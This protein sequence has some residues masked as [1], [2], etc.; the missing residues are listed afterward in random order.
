MKKEEDVL[1]KLISKRAANISNLLTWTVDDI[2][3]MKTTYN[4]AKAIALETSETES[5]LILNEKISQL[6]EARKLKDRSGSV[7]ASL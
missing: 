7:E 4:H 3:E 2:D 5:V 1:T 6:E